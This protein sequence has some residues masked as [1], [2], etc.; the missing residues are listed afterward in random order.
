VSGTSDPVDPVSR[1]DTADT[2]GAEPKAADAPPDSEG[3]TLRT[4]AYAG[5]GVLAALLAGGLLL[6][7]W[8]R[9]S[10]QA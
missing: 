5:G 3:S 2:R 1:A 7:P 8:L 4:V 10:R 9:G 6:L